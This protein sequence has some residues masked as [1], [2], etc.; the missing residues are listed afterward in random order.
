MLNQPANWHLAKKRKQKERVH[1]SLICCAL[2][3]RS[4]VHA[5]GT[6]KNKPHKC[7]IKVRSCV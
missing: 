3:Y 5:L 7:I 1:W 4:Y 6:N 2:I